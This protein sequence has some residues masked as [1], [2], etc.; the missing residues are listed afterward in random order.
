MTQFGIHGDPAVAAEWR[1]KSIK[2]RFASVRR[3]L[4]A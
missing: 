1:S 3:G 4:A 2:V